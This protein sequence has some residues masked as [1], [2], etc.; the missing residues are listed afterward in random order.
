[1][2][3]T[4]E[5]DAAFNSFKD[6]DTITRL[7]LLEEIRKY[8][9]ATYKDSFSYLIRERIDYLTTVRVR[10]L[11]PQI[12]EIV[13][14]ELNNPSHPISLYELHGNNYE[15]QK[16]KE[17]CYGNVYFALLKSPYRLSDLSRY[18]GF[19][20]DD[21]HR[22]GQVQLVLHYNYLKRVTAQEM[23]TKLIGPTDYGNWFTVREIAFQND[24]LLT[25][26][27]QK[28]RASP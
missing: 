15:N 21:D 26:S 24:P 22:S 23:V 17:L 7:E 13:E 2:S 6:I 3:T 28:R 9:D 20:P 16:I 11:E 12:R 4:S 19:D 14:T 18:L 27:A 10:E 25:K 5:L 8:T 1:M